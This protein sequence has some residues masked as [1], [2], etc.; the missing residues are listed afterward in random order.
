MISFSYYC[1][2]CTI[3]EYT[4]NLQRVKSSYWFLFSSTVISFDFSEVAY[5]I[6]NT[7]FQTPHWGFTILLSLLR[8]RHLI[9]LMQTM[10][11]LLSLAF[12]DLHR[13]D[14]S[15]LL[16]CLFLIIST[17]LNP[18]SRRI[19]SLS[20][21]NIWGICISVHIFMLF[22]LTRLTYLSSVA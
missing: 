22:F 6:K 20:H 17:N 11:R 15:S 7:H 18:L 21:Q 14:P 9:F 10:S 1:I 3:S 2:K 8:S 13:T 12:R 19:H 4:S 5:T 16:I